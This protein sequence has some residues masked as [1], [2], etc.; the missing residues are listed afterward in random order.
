MN[1]IEN[2]FTTLFTAVEDNHILGGKTLSML[3]KINVNSD[4]LFGLRTR[5]LCAYHAVF[6]SI[7][8]SF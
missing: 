8:G 7:K 4:V 2:K 5:K 1:N 3:C 6:P